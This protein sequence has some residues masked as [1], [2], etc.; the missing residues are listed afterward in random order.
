MKAPVLSLPVALLILGVGSAPAQEPPSIP[1]TLSLDDALE[2]AE[3]YN[4]TYRQ[5]ANDRGPAAWAVR[6]AYAS[7]LPTFTVSS[8]ATYQGAGTQFFLTN[9]F[10]QQQLN[11]CCRVGTLC[12]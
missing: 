2:L 11:H 1:E 4:P 12:A 8:N 9:E 7:F 5:T 10:T 3:R 6:N